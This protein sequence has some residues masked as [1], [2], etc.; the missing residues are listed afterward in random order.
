[1][2][3]M[4]RLDPVRDTGYT[5][6]LEIGKLTTAHPVVCMYAGNRIVFDPAFRPG[7]RRDT[8]FNL[9]LFTRI[10]R[11]LLE[12]RGFGIDNY[13][14]LSKREAGEF[15]DACLYAKWEWDVHWISL[16]ADF[17]RFSACGS[18]EDIWNRVVITRSVLSDSRAK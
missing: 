5:L 13:A 17:A 10:R 9:R 6:T 12:D 2:P 8:P 4:I 1:M 14:L 3:K 16:C 7:R 15:Y 11:V 18:F